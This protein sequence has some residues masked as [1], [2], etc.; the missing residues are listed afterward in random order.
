MHVHY[1]ALCCSMRLIGER[2]CGSRYGKNVVSISDY[3]WCEPFEALI[4][5]LSN[6]HQE[7]IKRSCLFGRSNGFPECFGGY[8]LPLLIHW[9]IK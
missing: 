6:S 9:I 5:Q 8:G 4:N 1:N 2:M 3:D 7:V